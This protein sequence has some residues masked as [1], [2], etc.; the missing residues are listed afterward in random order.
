MSRAATVPSPARSWR[1]IPQEIAPRAMS[2]VGRKR[3]TARTVRSLATVVVVAAIAGGVF[4]IWRTWRQSPELLATPVDSQPV[5][6]IKVQSD[7]VLT[8]SWVERALALPRGISLME[9]DLYALRTR[10]MASGQVS[11]A[12]LTREFPDVLKVSLAERSPIVRVKAQLGT[13][14][15]RDFLVARDGTVFLGEEYPAAVTE[16]L[17]WLG[18]I[19]LVREGSGFLP[20]AG[21]DRVA[22][23]L[24]SALTHT[25][26]LYRGWRVIS[27]SRL[28]SDHEIVVQ[29]AEVGEIT[30]GLREDF[31]TQLARLDLIVEQTGARGEQPLRAVNLAVGPT[32]VPVSFAPPVGTIGA[33]AP[34]SGARNSSPHL[35]RSSRQREF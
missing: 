23:L 32:Q 30:F 24:G 13:E 7:G 28:K 12:V 27:L 1:D 18:G 11:S 9:L 4:E 33:F 5:R 2:R 8:E 16:S 15:P 14:A 35:Q 10:L 6:T 21:M 29:A 22:D 17:P 3:V 25:P 20:L 26:R 19:R 31:Y 34:P